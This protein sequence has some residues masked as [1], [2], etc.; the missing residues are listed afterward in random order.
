[1]PE[2]SRAAR[3]GRPSLIAAAFVLAMPLAWAGA[4]AERALAEVAAIRA[5]GG[6]PA[7]TS[8]RI[9]VKQ[10]NI[11]SFVGRDR[12]L[13]REWERASG[14][15]I[16]ASVMPQQ[17]ALEFIRDNR[18]ID[19]TIARNHEYPDLL[20]AG[21]IENLAPMLRSFGFDPSGIG[22]YGFLLYEMQATSGDAVAA[23]PA[24]FDA[25]MLFLRG[26]LLQDPARQAAYLEQFGRPLAPPR[27]WDEY[28]RQVQ[29]FDD[30]EHGFHGA[31]EPRER[32]TGWMYWLPRYLVQ[33]EP[34]MPLF[35]DDMHPLIDSPEGIEATRSY[36]AT[37]PYSPPGVT[38]E[39]SDYSYTLPMF[40]Q[41]SGYS[42]I[43]TIAAAKL[44]GSGASKIRGRVTTVPVPGVELQGGRILRRP[45]IMYGNNLV[46][47]RTARHKELA[48]LY[49]MWL[50]DVDVSTRS[51]G[52]TGGFADPY[53]RHHLLDPRVRS[54]YGEQALAALADSLPD[55]S[56]P[57]TGLP[58]DAEYLA[59]LSDNLWRAA[60][61]EIDARTAMARTA[62]AWEEITERRGRA[63]QREYWRR[64]R[65]LYPAG[66]GRA[67]W[68]REGSA[69]A[70]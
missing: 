53:R 10:G 62:A 8:L 11:A 36:L 39:H 27:S 46:I 51:V 3:W 66:K 50:T 44:A 26:D 6:I 2:S 54:V 31:L 63:A 17:A 64:F 21:L 33:R 40:L 48:L 30:P 7:G 67:A 22:A 57:G 16:D 20:A 18:G 59:A 9:V 41:G 23:V 28:E 37:I 25:A 70:R 49:A 55:V 5:A 34:V 35:D 61:G 56:P 14:V 58:G 69:A 52:V 13:Q 42:T 1:M 4:Q 32:A 29:F 24:D 65:R 38:G 43:I 45:V 15:L 19:L 68:M 60:R 12:E 47:P